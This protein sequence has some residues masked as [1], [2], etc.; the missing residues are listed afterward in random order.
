MNR[1]TH[2]AAANKRSR[3]CHAAVANGGILSVLCPTPPHFM[4]I[5]M[6]LQWGTTMQAAWVVWKTGCR[7]N[8]Y[9]PNEPVEVEPQSVPVREQKLELELELELALESKLGRQRVAGVWLVRCCC[10]CAVSTGRQN[11]QE[12]R[13][14]I[15]IFMHL[16]V[17]GFVCGLLRCS[18]QLY[19][20]PN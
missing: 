7:A 8:S 4:L 16:C 20:L 15:R 18:W 1:E 13:T 11:E 5:T 12:V 2:Y 14:T 10:C 17:C 9:L 3:W 19:L 6:V